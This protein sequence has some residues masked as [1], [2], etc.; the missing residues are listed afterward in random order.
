MSQTVLYTHLL[1]GKIKNNP[2]PTT[3]SPTLHSCTPM[4]ARSIEPC[5]A[6][7]SFV[8]CLLAALVVSHA[9]LSQQ[10]KWHA[11]TM[12]YSVMTGCR[13]WR[14]GWVKNGRTGRPA[15]RRMIL[16]TSK[17]ESLRWG[18]NRSSLVRPAGNG[19]AAGSL[20]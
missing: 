18:V 11:C 14:A 15:G 19:V 1:A 17:G 10:N 3:V 5:L 20:G 16:Q 12:Y 9:S 4:D 2:R 7:S 6:A 8:V 13:A